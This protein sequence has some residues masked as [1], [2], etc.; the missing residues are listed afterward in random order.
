MWIVVLMEPV[1]PE[2]VNMAGCLAVKINKCTVR[3][4]HSPAR[5]Y[6]VA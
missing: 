5:R 6:C 4:T 1:H 2:Q 3:N